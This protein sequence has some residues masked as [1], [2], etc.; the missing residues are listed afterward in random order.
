MPAVSLTDH[1]SLAGAVDL[2]KAARDEG[3]KP[4]LGCEVYVTDDRNVAAEGLGAPHAARR[5][6]RGLRQPDQALL[7]RLPRGLLLQAARRLG[8]ARAARLG[9]DRALGLPLRPRVQGA[10]GEPRATTPRRSSTGSSRSSAATASTSSCRTRTSTC[11]SGSTRELVALAEKRGLPTRRDRRRPLP[12]ALRRARPRG[13]ALHPVGRLA[14]EPEPLEVRDRPLL[15]QDA[16]GDGA[17]LPR[18]RRRDAPHA[19]G[20]RA[21][22]RRDRARP[23]PAAEVPDARRPRRLRVPRRA[24]REGRSRSATARSTPELRERLQFELKTIKRDG[25]R[26]LLPDRRRLRRLREAQRRS[27]SARAAARPPARSSRT[28]SRSPT[29]T[30]SATTSSSSASST[31]AASRCPTWTSTSPSPAAS[32]SST[33]CARSTAAT[34]SRR[35]SPSGRWPRAPPSATPAACSSIPYGV[36]DKIAKLIPEGPGQML[37]DCLKPG[38]DLRREIDADPVAKEI[39][40][41]AQPLE[42][43]T[44]QD[45]IHAAAVVIGAEPLIEHGA[46]AAEGRRPGDRDAVRRHHDRGARPAQ[47]GLPRPAQPRRDRQGRRARAG[48]STSRPSRST[49]RRPTRCSRAASRPASSSSRAPGCARRCA[50]SSRPSSR[51]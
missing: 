14:Q 32:A 43:L 19:R 44:R 11:S 22:Q 48:A 30:R 50:R 24:V 25:L 6:E 12:P 40:D 8:A 7:A 21:L 38:A 1:G 29:S 5:D 9:P 3:V 34:A 2:Y 39:V 10:R 16:G 41:L 36:V 18:P 23:D 37:D 26:G 46:A 51:T 35:S 45:G 31:R 17:R 15:L 28:A 47:D 49:T 20:R 33:T 42:G 13:A 4:V 27:A